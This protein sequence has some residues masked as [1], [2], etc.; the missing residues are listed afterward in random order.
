MQAPVKRT[1][2][3][4]FKAA[5]GPTAFT[6]VELL[7]VVAVIAILA[8]LLLP[9]L[10]RAQE[11][12]RS[13]VCRSNLR[14]LGIALNAYLSDQRAYPFHDIGTDIEWG[15]GISDDPG[16]DKN[17][18]DDGD[19]RLAWWHLL[20]PYAGNKLWFDAWTNSDGW[21]VRQYLDR[22]GSVY[23]CPSL[24][25]LEG[26][27]RHRVSSY[28]YNAWG[29]SGQNVSASKLPALGLAGEAFDTFPLR[30]PPPFVRFVFRPT[31]ET[32]VLHPSGMLAIGDADVLILSRMLIF[33]NCPELHPDWLA[34]ALQSGVVS[35]TAYN[36]LAA[37][38]L[39]DSQKRHSGRW[40]NVFCDGHVEGLR[41]GEMF[42]FMQEQVRSRWN[43]DALPHPEITIKPRAGY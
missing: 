3:S 14:Q 29:L 32:D 18:D 12:G 24:A 7:V 23:A 43:K 42:D 13:A 20:V 22:D 19:V 8:A 2:T 38:W 37:R 11:A 26:G 17:A 21:T 27:C 6:L 31:R 25:N 4:R 35:P 41:M 5:A 28:G 15:I 40:Q 34:S 9:S 1:A 10:H 33:A 39:G 30:P 16:V 36:G